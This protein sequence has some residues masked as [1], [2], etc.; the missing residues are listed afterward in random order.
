MPRETNQETTVRQTGLPVLSEPT[1]R[2]RQDSE[3]LISLQVSVDGDSQV[4]PSPLLQWRRV[5]ARLSPTS[6]GT[7][8][9]GSSGATNPDRTSLE[10]QLC[11]LGGGS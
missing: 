5:Q 9:V 8:S 7:R 2:N 11:A 6:V 4:I 10:S 1:T 3:R